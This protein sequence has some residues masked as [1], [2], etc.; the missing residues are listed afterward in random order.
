MPFKNPA[1][2][3]KNR[4]TKKLIMTPKKCPECGGNVMD[5]GEDV[6]CQKCGLVIDEITSHAGASLE[7]IDYSD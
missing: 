1:V 4:S 7:G 6:Y 3:L 5:D 2:I